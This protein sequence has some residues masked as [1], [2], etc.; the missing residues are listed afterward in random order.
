MASHPPAAF[1]FLPRFTRWPLP[2]LS[3]GLLN[4]RLGWGTLRLPPMAS[5]SRFLVPS[6]FYGLGIG[7]HAGVG[8]GCFSIFKEPANGITP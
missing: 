6:C 1:V 4:R 5:A 3:G 7:G 2:I 8:A